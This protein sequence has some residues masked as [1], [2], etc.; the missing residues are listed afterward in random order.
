MERDRTREGELKK[1]LETE[2]DDRSVSLR[3]GK[4]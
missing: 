4:T 3:L 2:S 1:L